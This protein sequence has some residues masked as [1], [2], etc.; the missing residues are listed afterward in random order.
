[1]VGLAAFWISWAAPN[2]TASN[3]LLGLFTFCVVATVVAYGYFAIRH[4]ERLQT[5]EF[6]LAKLRVGVLGDERDPN[7]AKVIEA[8]P[9]A[10]P[11]LA[12]SHEEM[13]G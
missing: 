12:E 7:D 10:N 2:S 13:A 9:T 1:M 11:H 3:V 8:A 5:E 4:P 6:R